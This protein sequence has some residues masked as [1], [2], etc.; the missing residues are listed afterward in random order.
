MTAPAY[1]HL[2]QSADSYEAVQHCGLTKREL[3][4]MH[5]T[6]PGVSEIVTA[7]GLHCPDN[8]SVWH[9]ADTRIG[10]FN[11]WWSKLTNEE[12]FALSSKVKVQQADALLAELAKDG[13]P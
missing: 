11:E 9:D 13:V 3:F 7:A 8:F 5:A 12:R 4:A 10:S 2:A 1:P 6:Q